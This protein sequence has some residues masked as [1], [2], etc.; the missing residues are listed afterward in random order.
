M[1]D[2]KER[3]LSLIGLSWSDNPGCFERHLQRK[4]ENPLFPLDKRNFTQREVDLA[5][6][7]DQQDAA[8]FQEELESL[9]RTVGALP[10]EADWQQTSNL[11]EKIDV[12]LHRAAEIGGKTGDSFSLTLHELRK[13]LVDSQ[14]AAIADNDE[15]LN[16]LRAAEQF[17]KSGTL[18]F[19]NVFVAQMRREDTPIAREDIIPALLSESPDTIRAVMEILDGDVRNVIRQGCVQFLNEAKAAG[20]STPQLDEKLSALGSK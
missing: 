4:C 18:L 20:T 19:N 11:R 7:K 10:D 15:A 2:R 13:A 12:L 14:K 6:Q 17:Q 9:L 3:R 5:R 1:K 16:A 8:E